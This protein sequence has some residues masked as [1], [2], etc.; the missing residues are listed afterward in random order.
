MHR[1]RFHCLLSSAFSISSTYFELS[2]INNK[3]HVFQLFTELWFE[4][5]TEIHLNL[6]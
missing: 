1:P 2:E 4:A 5:E 6:F 3:R